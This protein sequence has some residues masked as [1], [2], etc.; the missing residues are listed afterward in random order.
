[1]STAMTQ[2]MAA[3]STK[4]LVQPSFG[5][6][7]KIPLIRPLTM[8]PFCVPVLAAGANLSSAPLSKGRMI[9]EDQTSVVSGWVYYPLN[10]HPAPTPDRR[11]AQHPKGELEPM[12]LFEL[13]S[14]DIRGLQR[15]EFGAVG[16][17]ERS[18]L[19]RLL[20][21][22]IDVISPDTL[23]ISEEFS[24]WDRSDRRIDLLG[25][26]RQARLV[27]VEL[28][29]TTDDSLADLQ[30]LRYAAMVSNMTFDEAVETFRRYL[31]RRQRE[32]DPKARLLEFLGWDGPTDGRFGEDVRIVLAAADF[33]AEVT[34]TVLW[35]NQ[36]D[37]DFACVRIQPYQLGPSILL[38]VQQIIPLPEAADYQVQIRQKQ[39]EVRA[40]A[41]QAMDWTR[42]DVQ[43]GTELHRTLYKREVMFV[44][45]RFLMRQG[46]SPEEIENTVGRHMFESTEGQVD[47]PTFRAELATRRP[48]DSKATKRFFSGDDQL[49]AYAGKTYALTNQWSKDT[50]EAAMVALLAKFGSKGLTYRVSDSQASGT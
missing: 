5:L 10:L 44:A 15:A 50:M 31:A 16:L 3:I 2:T 7:P 30:A 24:G 21:D 25:V 45:C 17:T 49:V 48:N 47:G 18:D 14:T 12:P 19:Q 6:P 4:V 32:D 1:M 41:E 28:K 37:L 8:I 23:V 13:S 38:D 35:L 29:R 9:K 43:A 46:V 22:H 33:S 26:D 34:S 36:R 40:A 42:Y 39:R 11:T 20:R 27:V